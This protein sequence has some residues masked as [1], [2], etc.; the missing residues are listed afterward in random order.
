MFSWKGK[1]VFLRRWESKG[2][3]LFGLGITG[4]RD[5]R[6]DRTTGWEKEQVE[7]PVKFC[8]EAETVIYI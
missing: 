5:T 7:V 1:P 4:I 8:I 6:R 2:R 3:I